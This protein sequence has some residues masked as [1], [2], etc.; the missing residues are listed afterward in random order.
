MIRDSQKST[1]SIQTPNDLY[2]DPIVLDHQKK[3]E[4]HTKQRVNELARKFYEIAVGRILVDIQMEE[5]ESKLIKEILKNKAE[6]KRV[7]KSLE[8]FVSKIN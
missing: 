5:L 6:Q 2:F 1:T 8:L 7:R 4:T 3:L